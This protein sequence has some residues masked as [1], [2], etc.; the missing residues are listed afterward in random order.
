M[1]A[2]V[3]EQL[4]DTLPISVKR[5]EMDKGIDRSTLGTRISRLIPLLLAVMVATTRAA[6]VE[7]FEDGT[8]DGD[9]RLTT[10]TN[11]VVEPSGGNPGAYLY[12]EVDAAVPTWYVP[13]GTTPTHFLGN[14]AKLDVRGMSF[15]VNIFAG[16]ETPNRNI[17]LD[18]ETTFGTGDYTKGVDAYYIG[19]DISNLPQG[20]HT[21]SFRIDAASPHIP[22]GWVVTRGNGKPGHDADWQALMQDVETIGLELGTPG[23]FYPDWI[24]DLG[25]DNVRIAQRYRTP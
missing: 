12:Q 18:I 17:T 22:P 11:P 1:L 5:L 4:I 16:I 6:F 20:W 3:C 19:A 21:Y 8:N 24:W 10:A 7:T 2:D 15:D 13:L 23:Y 25:L 14:Y 9:W